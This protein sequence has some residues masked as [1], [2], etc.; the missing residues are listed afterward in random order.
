ME[1][2]GYLA[3]VEGPVSLVMDL[4]ITHERWGSRSDPSIN[5]H[6]HYP[7]DV[8]RSLNES[9]TDKIRNY[10]TDYNNNPPNTISFMSVIVS[11]SGRV[12][13]EFVSLLFL[14]AQQETDRFFVVSGV[15]LVNKIHQWS[16]PLQGRGVLLTVQERVCQHSHQ[17]CSTE[18]HPER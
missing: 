1:L 9:V 8:D 15:Q 3:N 11:M 10:H 4:Y 16:V 17:V 2:V 5:G 14:Q 7:N 12:H 18:D 13:S 6:L